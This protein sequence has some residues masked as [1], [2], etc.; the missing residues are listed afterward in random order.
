MRQIAL[1]ACAKEPEQQ[2]RRRPG[3]H[4][5]PDPNSLPG[6]QQ[7]RR[8]LGQYYTT[9]YNPFR[10][11]PFTKWAGKAG[12]SHVLEPFAGGNHIIEMLREAGWNR[13]RAASYDIRPGHGAVER[14]DTIKSFPTGHRSCISNPPW[15][16]RSSAARRRLPYPATRY[17][18]V[19]KHCLGLALDNCE[20]VAFLIPASFLHSGLFRERLHSI[21]F[22]HRLAFDDTENPTCLALFHADR[23]GR[24]EVWH[25]RT[26]IGH[27]G[28]LEKML[29][30]PQHKL[31][32]AGLRFNDPH[33]KLGLVGVD[34]THAATIR[35]CRGA[36]L[37]HAI[38]HSSRS[39]TRISGIDVDDRVIGELNRRLDEFRRATHDVFL[40][41]FKGLRDDGK[42]RRRLDYRLAR[43]LIGAFAQWP[44]TRL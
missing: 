41:P 7:A 28:D 42:Y 4:P 27:L 20:N 23:A 11:K 38:L 36:E 14:R 24:T 33:G 17:D 1:Q 31:A 12:L 5:S 2:A 8:R 44:Q 15:L 32:A 37:P 39:V 43:R 40:T 6:D 22:L 35:F 21:V 16:G 9:N 19:Y 26:F 30:P 29:P 3:Q 25:D 34:D 18:D 10:L 13:V